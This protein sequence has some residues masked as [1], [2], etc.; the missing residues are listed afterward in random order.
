MKATG[1]DLERAVHLYCWN[2]ALSSAFFGPVGVLEVVLRNAFHEQLRNAFGATWHDEQHFLNLD[3]GFQRRIDKAKN[4]ITKRQKAITTPRIVAE[5]SMGFWVT[6]VNATYVYTL[7]G[8]ALS[9]AFT[10][11]TIRRSTISG[12]LEPLLRFRNRVAHHEPIFNKQPSDRY[13]DLIKV[14][15][16]LKPDVVPWIE[17]HSRVRQVI[18]DGPYRPHSRF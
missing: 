4:D 2:A 10:P 12:L 15:G 13:A 17:H 1:N 18:T 9:K 7:W 3:A 5:L 11:N 16:F 14:V 6:L 8:P